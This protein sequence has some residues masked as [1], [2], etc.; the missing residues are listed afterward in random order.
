MNHNAKDRQRL[1]QDSLNRV[2]DHLGTSGLLHDDLE[3]IAR[4]L[5]SS[6]Y[7]LRYEPHTESIQILLDHGSTH[8]VEQQD[9]RIG[10]V[11][12]FNMLIE[13]ENLTALTHLAKDFE[14]GIDVVCVD[15]PYNTGM[16]DLGYNDQAFRADADK[17]SRWLS[18]MEQRLALSR[19]LMSDR[20]VLFLHVD[21]TEAGAS[22][23]LCEQV[24]GED[25]FDVLIWPKTDPRFDQNRLDKPF[26]TV[27]LVHEYVIVCYRDRDRV[28]LN[29]V[30][31]PVLLEGTWT[32][33][34][35]ELESILAGWGT[36][37]SAKDELVVV[38]GDRY[39]F[40]TP[41]PMRLVKE[42]VRAASRRDSVVLDIFA[43]SGTTGH[44]VMDLNRDDNSKRT[45]ILVNSDE[46]DICRKIT[47]KRL[48]S[49]M[50]R[51]R[52][53]ESLRFFEVHIEGRDHGESQT[54]DG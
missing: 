11:L 18:F 1:I 26:R 31:R 8:L 47:Y 35:Q 46:N 30:L 49:A 41:K 22:M 23:L 25:N 4:E 12:P 19:T 2:R 38:F 9:L 20:G 6:G 36:T 28:S 3:A 39:R 45:F 5:S 42:L 51:E 29:Q 40:Q 34:S 17:H 32:E 14:S 21:E 53:S 33:Q 37:S 50:E 10:S 16:Q 15:P 43:G 7:R 13:A 48:R 44:A 27:K 52:Y 54:S 24:F